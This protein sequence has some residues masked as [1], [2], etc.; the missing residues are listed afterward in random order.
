MHRALREPNTGKLSL[1]VNQMVVMFIY[2]QAKLLNTFVC[3]YS[4]LN[5]CSFEN[6][7]YWMHP[8]TSPHF[9]KSVF[10]I[11]LNKVNV[12]MCLFIQIPIKQPC[13]E[14]HLLTIYIHIYI[15]R[16]EREV[17]KLR[18]PMFIT[19]IIRSRVSLFASSCDLTKDVLWNALMFQLIF[20][21]MDCHFSKRSCFECWL[22]SIVQLQHAP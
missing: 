5:F 18:G 15:L 10:I 16:K 8:P 17:R 1:F 2:C 21:E 12:F 11:P 9:L 22:I 20:L 19:R 7:A 4:L 6:I 13:P 14:I 3:H